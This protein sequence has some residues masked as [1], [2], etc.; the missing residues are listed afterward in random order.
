[1]GTMIAMPTAPCPQ[2]SWIRWYMVARLNTKE[3]VALMFFEEPE[4]PRLGIK[5]YHYGD[6]QKYMRSRP[7]H[8]LN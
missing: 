8:R 7:P 5:A 6:E 4:S 2:G 3:K 1:M